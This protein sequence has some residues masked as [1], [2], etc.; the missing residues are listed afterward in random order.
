MI[1]EILKGN[2]TEKEVEIKG[3]IHNKRSSGSIVFFIIRDGSG[4]IQAVGKKDEL[5]N[6]EEIE[7]LTLESSIKIKGIV[8]KEER[9]PGGYEVEIKEMNILQRADEDFPFMRKHKF[10]V[11]FIMKNRHLWLRSEKM[12]KVLTIRSEVIQQ[13]RNWFLENGYKEFQSPIFVSGACEGGST[14]F[15]VNYFGRKAYLTQSWQLY[16]EAAIF[17]LGKIFTIAPSFRAEKSKTRRHLTEYWHVEAEIPFCGLDD[18]LKEEESLVCYVCNKIGEKFENW[19]KE[20]GRDAKYLKGLSPPFPRIKYKE[21]IEILQNKNVNIQYGNDL[22]ADEEKILTQEFETPFFVTHF[23]KGIKAFYHKIDR[24][25]PN[26]T[27]SADLLAPE[28]Y[29]EI[30]GSGERE[31]NYQILKKRVE[32]EGLSVK[33]YKWYLDLRRYGSVQHSG[34]GLGLERFIMWI[35][36]LKHIRETIAFPRLIGKIHF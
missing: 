6:F 28:G 26:V 23:P 18:L 1:S 30:I 3:W 15:E 13:I 31:D 33:E 22:G 5:K 2:L 4:I 8:K 21:A 29:G 36:K 24:E 9:A 25:N 10:N 12:F 32:E 7:K 17:S 35:C 34:F 11:N 16:A 27:L 14:L 19:L 20:F